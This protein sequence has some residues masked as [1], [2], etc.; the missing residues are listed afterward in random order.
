MAATEHPRFLNDIGVA[1]IAVGATEFECMGASSPHDHPHIYLDM[2]HTGRIR[3]PY[4]GTS[5][6]YKASLEPGKAEPPE[7][8][9]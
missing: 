7:C 9:A 4:C 2:G 5:F 6:V 8:A 3:C 1:E